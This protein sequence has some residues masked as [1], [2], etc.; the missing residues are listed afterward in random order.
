MSSS[1]TLEEAYRS[2]LSSPNFDLSKNISNEDGRK[3]SEA[4]TDIS[5]AMQADPHLTFDEARLLLVRAQMA[6]WGIDPTGMPL[7]PKAVT[8]GNRPSV[9]KCAVDLEAQ[10]PAGTLKLSLNGAIHGYPLR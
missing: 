5:Q 6:R 4:V 8:F 2:G 3:L 9:G 1:P 10:R 7:D